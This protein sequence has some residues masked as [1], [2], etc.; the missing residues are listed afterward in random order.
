MR[1]ALLVLAFPAIAQAQALPPSPLDAV[2]PRVAPQAIEARHRIHQNPELGNREFETAKL[3]AA[4]LRS[5]GMEVRT[6]IAHTGVVGI[7]KGGRPGPLVA[8]RADIDAL[9]VTEEVDVP[10]KSTV[11]TK[12]NGQDVGVM[13]AC[14]HDIHVAVQ[15]GVASM[16]AGMKDRLAGSVMFIFQ[17]AEE[18]APEGE[19]GG[20]QLMLK[21]GLF[22]TNKP[23]AV[24]GLHAAA[25][26]PVGTLGYRV[27]PTSAASDI[28]R[29]AFKGRQ[30]HGAFPQMS[31]DPIVMAS[32]AVLALQ[33]IRSR[34][35][36]PLEAS[37]LTVGSMHSGER[38][39]IIPAEARLE[40]TVRTYSPA[41]RDLVEKRMKEIA[42]GIAAAAGGTAEVRY[43]RGYP[44]TIND[45]VLAARVAP[46]L[47]KVVGK[48]R[49]LLLD[50]SMAGEDFSFFANEVPGFFYSLGV[51][52]PGTT[53]GGH[54]T[55]TFNA[56]DSAIPVGIKAMTTIVLDF[57][58]SYATRSN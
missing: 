33:T 31:V 48:G 58:E 23:V 32:Q 28:F 40:G 42:D 9:P 5:L 24:F 14:G 41:V 12:Y 39:N 15:L 44:S 52:K 17:P 34:N 8:V 30:A 10:F 55:P 21:E 46:S 22:R 49:V 50:P 43:T 13:H 16:L 38:H 36:P 51:T 54:H 20:A 53:S 11:R 35:V 1:A 25:G 3:V 26:M 18:M 4:H 2:L 27:G 57:L 47:E 29:I 37:V 45:S 7:L 6:G 56:D 19:E